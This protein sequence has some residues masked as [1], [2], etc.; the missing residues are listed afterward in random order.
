LGDLARVVAAD[1][2][3]DVAKAGDTASSDVGSEVSRGDNSAGG[4]EGQHVVG[5]RDVGGGLAVGS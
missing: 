3:H 1:R 5:Q 2:Q 4:V